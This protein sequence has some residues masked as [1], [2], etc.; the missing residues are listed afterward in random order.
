M[1]TSCDS[2]ATTIYCFV[3]YF[4]KVCYYFKRL[5]RNQ[6]TIAPFGGEILLIERTSFVLAWIIASYPSIRSHNVWSKQSL[7]IPQQTLG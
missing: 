7:K 1:G 4:Q 3:F 2:H 6:S 5:V